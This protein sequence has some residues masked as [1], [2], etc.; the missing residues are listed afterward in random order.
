M[1]CR[2]FTAVVLCAFLFALKSA[3]HDLWL[4][5]PGKAE[6]KQ[7]IQIAASVGMDFPVSVFASATDRYPR[8]FVLGPDGATL[9][10]SSA[11]KKG[12]VSF[13][14]FEPSV[15]GIHLLAVQTTPKVLELDAD[16]F[17]DYLVTDGLPHIYRLR[18]KEKTLNQPAKERYSKSPTAVIAVGASKTGDWGKVLD[19]PL[20]IVPMQNPF[21]AK[22]GATLRVRVLFQKKPLARANLGWQRPGDGDTPI[23]YVRTDAKGEALI[24]IAQTGLMTIRLTHMTRPKLAAYEWESFWTTLTFRIP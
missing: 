4:V 23:G 5:P 6:P 24:P 9:P 1:G 8:K 20:Q 13:L 17:N 15:P 16:R 22:I 10:L 18:A 21:D 7:K 19:L 11:G 12:L 3:G 2:N 14:E